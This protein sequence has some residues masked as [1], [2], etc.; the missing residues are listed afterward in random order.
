M[1]EAED[2]ELHA[3]LDSCAQVNSRVKTRI[4]PEERECEFQRILDHVRAHPDERAIY[5]RA[6]R[7]II[8]G[9]RHITDDI[10]HFSMRQ[11][12]WPEVADAV[13]ERMSQEIH[14]SEYAALQK[15]LELYDSNVA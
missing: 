2:S 15:I 9:H 11:L 5:A 14:N 3:F 4:W 10:V 12:S 7:M 8:F 1:S 6:F 13:R